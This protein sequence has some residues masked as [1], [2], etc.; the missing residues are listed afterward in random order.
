MSAQEELI[1]QR[2]Y[3][4]STGTNLAGGHIAGV[5]SLSN[6]LVAIVV[7]PILPLNAANSDELMHVWW[8]YSLLPQVLYFAGPTGIISLH[9][10]SMLGKTVNYI[11]QQYSS[12]QSIS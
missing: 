10:P 5:A 8:R 7:D 6:T 4:A 1:S 11:R 3:K 9:N 2:Q 12:A